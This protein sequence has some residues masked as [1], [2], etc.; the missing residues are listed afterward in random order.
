MSR[1]GAS[2]A[3]AL[4]LQLASATASAQP[5]PPPAPA[6]AVQLTPPVQHALLR[7][8]EE[9]LEWIGAF[10]QGREERAE[11][12]VARLLETAGQAGMRRLPDLALAALV[13]AVEWAEKGDFARAR[14]GLAA[15]E[16][17]DPGRPETAFAAARVAAE[18]GRFH[19]AA[20]WTAKAYARLARDPA[21]R[22]VWLHD[23]L[24]WLWTALVAAGVLCLALLMATRGRRLVGDL[25]ALLGRRLPRPLAL[26]AAVL[27]L[28]WPAALPGGPAWLVLYWTILL[29][30][31]LSLSER[32]VVAALLL[33]IGAAPLLLGAQG[34]RVAVAVSPPMRAVEGVAAGRLYGALFN[35]LAALRAA[36]PESLAVRQLLADVHRRLGQWELARPLYREVLAREK[37]NTSALLDFG[38]Y[39]FYKGDFG[40]AIQHFQQAATADPESAAAHFNLSKAYAE[41][42]LF[43]ERERAYNQAQRLDPDKVSEW[44]K[45]VEQR[46]VVEEGG[47]ARIPEI[48]RQ[49]LAAGDA[50]GA[51]G[52]GLPRAAALLL[53]V[54]VLG[55]A[56]GLRRVRGAVDE[57]DTPPAAAAGRAAR[58]RRALLPGLAAAEAGAGWRAYGALLVPVALLLLPL[59][60]RIGY[61]VPWGHEPG[62]AAPWIVASAGLLVY[63]GA[64]LRRELRG[65]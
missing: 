17:L 47:V 16:R 15:A 49:L 20:A 5:P 14:L 57:D 53:A 41:A 8:Q 35:D 34:R 43:R 10:Y 21:L 59:A 39:Y 56:F 58:W 24:V 44:G 7:L 48:R 65:G 60:A 40:G 61:R 42:Y 22:G 26:A 36:L 9:W 30:A 32:A 31:Y 11:R 12:V 62:V 33:L 13:P 2:A 54:L 46:V 18:E 4:A 1:R 51:A 55:A 28:V 63:L 64:R 29:W 3:V 37:E 45:N 27:L 23:A 25:A 19:A 52:G 6:P 50:G 38:A